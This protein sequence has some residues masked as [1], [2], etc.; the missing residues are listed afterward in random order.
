[1]AAYRKMLHKYSVCVK[2]SRRKPVL[3][4]ID[5]VIMPDTIIRKSKVVAIG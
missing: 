2:K 4:S 3:A 5:L 1:M